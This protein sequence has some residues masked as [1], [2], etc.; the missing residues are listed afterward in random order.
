MDQCGIDFWQNHSLRFLE[1]V[2]QANKREVLR[3]PD[4]YGKSSRGECGDTIEIFL[5]LRDGRIASASFETNGCLYTLASAN[6]VVHMVEG[7]TIE[8]AWEITP[9]EVMDYLETLPRAEKHCAQLA[10]RTLQHALLDARENQRHPWKKFY[11]SQ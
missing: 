11:Q 9:E 5:T 6:A 10:V 1:M 7:K 2:F 4:G 3:N 8:D